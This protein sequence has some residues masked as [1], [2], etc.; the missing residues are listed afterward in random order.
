MKNSKFTLIELLVVIAIIGIL[1]S[2][3]LPSLEKAREK[4]RRAVCLSNNHQIYLGMLSYSE[5]NN[6]NLPEG[7]S[8]YG[9]GVDSTYW[10]AQNKSVGA[11]KLVLQDYLDSGAV[12][13]CP[14]W[15]QPDKQFGIID[16]DGSD[17]WTGP[18]GFGGWPKDPVAGPWPTEHVG[19]SY[20]YRGTFGVDAKE[21]ANM[22]EYDAAST[23]INAD[24]WTRREALMG[25]TYGHK[26]AYVTLYLDGHSKIRIDK[27]SNYMMGKQ[28]EGTMTND[29]WFAQE[30]IWQEFFDID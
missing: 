10:I 13:Y 5:Q 19:S 8:F 25:L 17:F 14:S 20:H 15:S 18:N 16:S 30:S 22:L 7:N 26:D 4:G 9:F 11:A 23:A 29:S 21:S 3:L 28:P 27:N 1:A 2:L 24:H 12:M 6:E